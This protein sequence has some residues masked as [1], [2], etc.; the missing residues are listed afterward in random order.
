MPVRTRFAPSP[1]GYM[2]IGNLRTALY[3]YLI[4]RSN[5]GVFILRIEDTDAGRYVPGA[6][7]V[8]Y[9]TLKIAGLTYDEGPDIGGQYGP[10]IQSERRDSYMKYALELVEK[11]A[12]Y[13]CFCAPER[14]RR[15]KSEDGFARY[16][17][18]CRDL[19]PEE[20]RRR[21]S[22]GEPSVIRQRIPAGSTA[23]YD[24]I[25]G[26]ITVENAEMEDQ[27]LIKS[28]GLPTYNFANVVDDHLMAIT[29]VV[30]GNEYLSSTP[31]YNL[32]YDALGWEKP[33]YVHLP[34]ILNAGG[35]KMSKRHG[36]PSFEDVL[37]EGFLPEAVINYIALLGWSPE[38]NTEFFTLAELER[39][40]KLSGLSK[41]PSIFDTQKLRWFNA[42][43]IRR[44][45]PAA[46]Y[47]SV[48]PYFNKDI[49][50]PG[51]DFEKMAAMAQSRVD[52]IKDAPALFDFIDELPE[53]SAELY[54][55]KKMKTTP[56][57]ALRALGAALPALEGLPDNLWSEAAIHD[58]LTRL[59]QDMELK[60]GQMLWPVRTALSGKPSSPCGAIEL[61]ELLGREESLKRIKFGI[62]L[63]AGVV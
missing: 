20:A 53:Y 62:N 15:L 29:H 11:C 38:D 43:Y 58:C 26:S 22:A 14:L 35:Q 24:E 41:S 34:H 46:F 49:K 51:L 17:G 4:A 31:K 61:C 23:F 2:H 60:T 54:V 40:F 30:R 16:D 27:V 21:L 7:D 12:A 3:E 13:H 1:T 9:N 56:E 8:I 37:E 63:L 32:L 44:M 50:K 33:V 19:S 36:D 45:E 59:A 28:D 5:G 52:F 25:Y 57:I 42:E 55:H 47:Q 48:L 39:A 10:Y 18:H 6:V